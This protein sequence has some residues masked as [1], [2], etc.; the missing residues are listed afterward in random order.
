M[1]ERKIEREREKESEK[2]ERA[3]L[4]RF[5]VLVIMIVPS[6]DIRIDLKSNRSRLNFTT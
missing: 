3:S 5:G 2:K 4:I 6:N 1:R